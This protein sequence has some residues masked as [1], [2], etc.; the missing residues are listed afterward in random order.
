M[1]FGCER[2]GAPDNILNPIRSAA[3][4]TINSFW[5]R[6]GKVE[7][8]ARIPAGD[9]LWPALWM[10]P[11]YDEYGN[12]PLSGEIDI[13]ESR[14]NRDLSIGGVQ[15]GA[16]QISQTIHFPYSYKYHL[17]NNGAGFDKNFHTYTV[18]WNPQGMRY[19]LDGQETTFIEHGQPFDKEFYI[20]MNLAIGGSTGY[21][22]EEAINGNGREWGNNEKGMTDFWNSRH[23]TWLPTWNLG[24]NN[25]K[26]A[27]FQIDYVRVFAL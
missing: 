8:R 23:G 24:I 20:I 12:W 14:G 18:E 5:F 16:Q 6:Y 25:D 9:W 19:F 27:S 13:M 10:L 2:T 4:R 15:I 22:P 11:K 17:I 21:F 7:I 1:F 26:E 3:L